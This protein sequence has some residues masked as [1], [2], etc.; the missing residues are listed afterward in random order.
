MKDKRRNLNTADARS[1]RRADSDTDHYVVVAE[2]GERLSVSKW[3]EQEFYIERFNLK[4][5][6]DVEVK[7]RTISDAN[8]KQVCSF[9]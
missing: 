3:A 8:L 5:L 4:K 1:F 6:N 2:V 7:V 9:E